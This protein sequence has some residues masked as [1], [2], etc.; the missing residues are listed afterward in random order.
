MTD[1]HREVMQAVGHSPARVVRFDNRYCWVVHFKDK[2]ID[3]VR[4]Y[5][6]SAMV[7]LLFVGQNPI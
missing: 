3:R 5:L 7:A 6:D 4:A 1:Q 2:T